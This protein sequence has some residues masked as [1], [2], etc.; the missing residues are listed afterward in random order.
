[1]N[2]PLE[3]HGLAKVHST[4]Y[5]H[6]HYSHSQLLP[7]RHVGTQQVAASGRTNVYWTMEQLQETGLQG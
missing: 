3:N 7:N 4:M 1:M 6:V 2:D 5:M